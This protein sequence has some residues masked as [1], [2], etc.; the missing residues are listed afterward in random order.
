MMFKRFARLIK[1]RSGGRLN[2]KA[3][4]G[5]SSENTI[6]KRCIDGTIQSCGV[7]VGALS[8]RVKDLAVLELP[9]L[10]LDF[11]EVD[12]IL[13][14]PAQPHVKKILAAKNLVFYCWSENGWR[15]FGTREEPIR[16]PGDLEGL[17]MR[18][19][20]SNL[21]VA[22][23]RALKATPVALG[24][25]DVVKALEKEQVDGFDQSPM[26][27]TAASW[28]KH[29]KYYTLTRHIFQPAV[30]VFNKKFFDKLPRDL[31]KVILDTSAE[32][33]AFGRKR[34]RAIYRP[35]I[36]NLER[37]GIKVI[38]LTPAQRV[39]FVIATKKTHLRVHRQLSRRA[40]RLLDVIYKAKQRGAK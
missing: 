23:Y 39:P 13:D 9:Y 22:M 11:K 14:G 26:Y 38:R 5:T 6:V 8:T 30:V 24:L 36:K 16:K 17:K 20:E 18:A 34:I 33:Q 21:H 7:T 28:H 27:L 1:T 37:E 15:S 2:T 29:I 3:K 12:G 32:V 10:F 25:P 31:Q 19:M 4:F 40:R 35:L